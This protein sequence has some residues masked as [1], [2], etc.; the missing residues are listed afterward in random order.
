MNSTKVVVKI[1]LMNPFHDEEIENVN[2]SRGSNPFDSP[3]PFDSSDSD[4]DFAA[5]SANP[6]IQY[7]SKVRKFADSSSPV[8]STSPVTTGY[9]MVSSSR[10]DH[11]MI[12]ISSNQ[13]V[14]EHQ[15]IVR[16][17]FDDEIEEI[18]FN[19]FEISRNSRSA[20]SFADRIK[21]RH[22]YWNMLSKKSLDEKNK[23]SIKRSSIIS[24][25]QKYTNE[26]VPPTTQ[27]SIDV[28]MNPLAPKVPIVSIP[29]KEVEDTTP[30]SSSSDI[31]IYAIDPNNENAIIRHLLKGRV[32][33]FPN[34]YGVGV[35]NYLFFVFNNHPL[36]SIFLSHRLHP[37]AKKK[38]LV[39]LMCSLCFA[40]TVTYV[41]TEAYFSSEV[42]CLLTFL[43]ATFI[44]NQP[45]FIGDDM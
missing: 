11:S 18:Q 42:S 7:I 26:K 29:I 38:R 37:F 14:N 35:L 23:E 40:F 34:S 3:N 32:Y 1:Q 12:G 27:S 33:G 15:A 45:I 19:S 25:S 4:D 31:P 30:S 8:T 17:P 13:L 24:S 39:V 41:L 2:D 22:Q 5:S 6:F 21:V 9:D 44:H 16:N 20:G 43:L 10:K 28:S 36:L